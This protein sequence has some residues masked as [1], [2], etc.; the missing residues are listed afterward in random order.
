M[1]SETGDEAQGKGWGRFEDK[2]QDR[3]HHPP[4]QIFTRGT[5]FRSSKGTGNN[6]LWLDHPKPPLI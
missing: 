5:F 2:A 3:W 1:R 6:N 4:P